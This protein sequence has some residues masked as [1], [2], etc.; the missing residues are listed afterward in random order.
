MSVAAENSFDADLAY[1]HDTGFTG[2][3]RQAAPWLVDLLRRRGLAGGLVVELG[4][5]TG[6]LTGELFQ[7]GFRV[8]GIDLSPAML[9]L[10]RRHVPGTQFVEESLWTARLP[11]CAAVVSVGECLNYS[12]DRRCGTSALARLFRRVHRA[13]DGNGLLVFDMLEPGHL[14]PGSPRRVWREGDDWAA[15]VHVEV[16]DGVLTRQITTFRRVGKLYR[17]GLEIHREILFDR[18]VVLKQL[19]EAGFTARR[20][21]GYGKFRLR[22]GHSVFV[23][24]CSRTPLGRDRA[25]Q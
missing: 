14:E 8:H 10:A 25:R 22:R 18:A 24:T 4:C 2:F 6:A 11:R 17:R 13:L 5:G 16:S 7:A 15:L 1:I 12:F 3:A 9:Q 23:A 19:N 20:H 21:A